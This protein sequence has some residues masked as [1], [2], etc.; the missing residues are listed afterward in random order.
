MTNNPDAH[1]WEQA[2]ALA[3]RNY[4]LVIS[5]DT[6]SNGETVYVV[7]NPELPGCL[8]HGQT[9]SQ[10]MREL[11]EARTAYIYYLLVDGV[12]VPE[13]SGTTTTTTSTAQ[14]IDYTQTRTEP[15]EKGNLENQSS[16]V[17]VIAS[18]HHR[19]GE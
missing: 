11:V 1:L 9:L 7:S 19:S 2:E 4:E 10:A 15:L 18:G 13:P 3:A 17:L 16:R 8:A 12:D 5:I 6:L 14:I